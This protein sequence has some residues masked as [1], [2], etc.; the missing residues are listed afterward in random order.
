[1]NNT[2]RLITTSL[3][4]KAALIV[5][6]DDNENSFIELREIDNKG[7]MKEA[8]PVSLD[9]L[10][11]I[12]EFSKDYSFIPHGILPPNLLYS[13]VRKGYERFIWYNLPRK[14]MMY[15]SKNLNIDNAEYY[16]PGIIYITE[17]THLK[18]YAFKGNRIPNMKTK[19]YRGPFFNTSTAGVCLGNAK[20]EKPADLSFFQLLEYWEKLFWLTEF[21]HLSQ[22]P[23]KN[24]LVLVTKAA[25]VNPFDENELIE[26][27]L[28][29]KDILK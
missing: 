27:N 1:M 28:T 2:T 26:M 3:Q 18:T 22:N 24:N 15:F 6:A 20:L 11:C 23:V 19:L 21:S 16:M 29:L 9:F 7:K 25:K 10:N 5:Y 14:R 8:I 12:A 17:G 13:D 4:P